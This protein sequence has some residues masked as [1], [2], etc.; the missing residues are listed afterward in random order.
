MYDEDSVNT[1][2]F[3]SFIVFGC[4]DLYDLNDL[5]L[6]FFYFYFVDYVD[7]VDYGALCVYIYSLSYVYM[8]IFCSMGNFPNS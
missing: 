3:V 6:V 4:E 7:Y 8:S 2:G 1:T 5:L